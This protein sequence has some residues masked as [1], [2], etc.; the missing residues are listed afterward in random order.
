MIFSW[1]VRQRRKNID[2]HFKTKRYLQ[3]LVFFHPSRT[4]NSFLIQEIVAE[5]SNL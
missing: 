5:L 1:T 2:K 4:S 3:Y